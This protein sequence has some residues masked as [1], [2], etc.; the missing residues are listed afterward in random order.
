MR[1][2][3]TALQ[4]LDLSE[5]DVGDAGAVAIG[6]VLRYD[7]CDE[8]ELHWF[9]VFPVSESARQ[10]PALTCLGMRLD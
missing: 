8:L 2:H 1:R 9:H 6:E 4:T 5:N 7:V 3:N 10:L